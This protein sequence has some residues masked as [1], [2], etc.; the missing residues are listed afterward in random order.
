MTMLHPETSYGTL[1][2]GVKLL[3]LSLKLLNLNIIYYTK[4]VYI[5]VLYITY[6]TFLTRYI[7]VS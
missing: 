2:L 5:L 6:M 3:K 7:F 4:K 1:G